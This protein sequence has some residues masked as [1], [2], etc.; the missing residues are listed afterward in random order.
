MALLHA[1]LLHSSAVRSCIKTRLL[2]ASPASP[3]SRESVRVMEECQSKRTH[4]QDLV[5]CACCACGW[6]DMGWAGLVSCDSRATTC[7]AN[8][9]P[10]CCQ[11]AHVVAECPSVPAHA[12]FLSTCRLASWTRSWESWRRSVPSCRC[13]HSRCAAAVLPPLRQCAAHTVLLPSLLACAY[14]EPAAAASALLMCNEEF[15]ATTGRRAAWNAASQDC[16]VTVEHAHSPPLQEYQRHDR[17]RRSLE[18]TIYDK[19]LTKIKADIDKVGRGDWRGRACSLSAAGL[20]GS[21]AC[22]APAGLSGAGVLSLCSECDLTALTTWCNPPACRSTAAGGGEGGACGAAGPRARRASGGPGALEEQS[23][24][25]GGVIA[26]FCGRQRLMRVQAVL[27]WKDHSRPGA[28]PCQ[29]SG[30]LLSITQ[31]RLKVVERE[32]KTLAAQQKALTTQKQVRTCAS[33]WAALHCQPCLLVCSRCWLARPALRVYLL[34]D[35]L[36][37]RTPPIRSWRGSARLPSARRRALSWMWLTWRTSC[38]ATRVGESAIDNPPGPAPSR[39]EFLGCGQ[40]YVARIRL[41][42]PWA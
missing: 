42:P 14:S 3:R 37:L 17:A 27:V 2:P 12:I 39:R 25:E 41:D 28:S 36:C 20:Q 22:S 32:L 16:F 8:T 5:R 35:L 29:P 19:E 21:V 23:R 24:V 38:R 40:L 7:T 15:S 1:A 10:G 18:Y 6:A 31:S 13:V 34:T 4:I 33:Y 11:V 26:C 30:C 9:A